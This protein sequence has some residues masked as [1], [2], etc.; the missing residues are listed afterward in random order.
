MA[1]KP[2]TDSKHAGGRPPKYKTA[3]EMQVLIDKYFDRQDKEGRPYTV[4][5]LALALDMS[6]Q[7]LVNYQNKDEF[8]DTIKKA[9]QKVQEYNE[10]ILI[11]GKNV[12]GV[13]FNMKNNFGYTDTQTIDNNVNQTVTIKVKLD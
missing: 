12:A 9:K 7:D 3:K 4:T 8:F 11:N 2:Q 6:R 1:T 10:E 5:G 13:I